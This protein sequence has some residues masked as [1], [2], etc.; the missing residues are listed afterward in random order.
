LS[1]LTWQPMNVMLDNQLT[2]CICVLL[3]R[4]LLV[5]VI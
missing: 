5:L 3:S 2:Y 4:F 1:L